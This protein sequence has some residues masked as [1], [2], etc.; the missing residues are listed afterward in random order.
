MKWQM[1]ITIKQQEQHGQHRQHEQHGR[2]EQQGH[3]GQHRQQSQQLQLQTK[4][5]ALFVTMPDVV[6][7]LSMNKSARMGRDIRI[8][9]RPPRLVRS[10]R[11]DGCVRHPVVP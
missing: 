1:E 4:A 10:R 5:S 8:I 11:S 7:K 2:Q 6:K 3:H 9:L